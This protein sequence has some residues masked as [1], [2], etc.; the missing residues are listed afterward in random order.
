MGLVTVS[1]V[2]VA[3]EDEEGFGKARSCCASIAHGDLNLH[4]VACK[5]LPRAKWSVR[6]GPDVPRH[7]RIWRLKRRPLLPRLIELAFTHGNHQIEVAG[8]VS[9]VLGK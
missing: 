2:I 5:E 9:S 8:L 3:H 4:H 7:E 6:V 1:H